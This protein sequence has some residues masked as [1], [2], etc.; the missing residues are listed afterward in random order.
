MKLSEVLLLESN[1]NE[2]IHLLKDGLF[3]RAYD[4]SAFLFVTHIRKYQLTKKFYKNVNAEIVHLGFPDTVLEDTLKGLALANIQRDEK[5]IIIKGYRYE[6]LHYDNWKASISLK[7]G[8]AT[9]SPSNNN[10]GVLHRITTFDTL[11][12][13]PF[14]CQQFLVNLQKELRDGTIQ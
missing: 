7:T 1:N 2:T 9:N 8:K 6:K 11:N 13:T 12:K 3:W 14:E 10:T 5:L 4:L